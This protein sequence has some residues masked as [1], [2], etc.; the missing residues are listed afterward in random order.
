MDHI[1]DDPENKMNYTFSRKRKPW[2]KYTMGEASPLRTLPLLERCKILMK[3]KSFLHT[4]EGKTQNELRLALLPHLNPL[5]GKLTVVREAAGK[6]RI[7]AIN[8]F[9]TQQVLKPL[10]LWLFEICRYFPQDSTFDQE[11]SLSKFVQRTDMSEYFSYDLSSAT[12]LIPYQIYKAVLSPL[13]GTFLVDNWINILIDKTF[14]LSGIVN[15]KDDPAPKGTS[16]YTRGQPMGALSSW[17]LMNLSHHIINQYAFFVS[18]V[19]DLQIKKHHSAYFKYVEK[20]DIYRIVLTSDDLIPIERLELILPGFIHY[21]VVC[22]FR[23]NLL[24]F[25]RYVV[26][27]DDNV[28]GHRPTAESYF[29]LLTTVYDVPIKLAK[30]YVSSKLINFANQTFF[31]KA[32]ISP[33]PF[34][35]FLSLKGLGSRIEFATRTV[36]RFF[37]KPSIFGLLRYIVNS[38]SWELLKLH[39][40]LGRVYEPVLPLLY[41]VTII[42]L[43]MFIPNW[44][45][46]V[47]K[48]P[49]R[50]FSVVGAVIC[51]TH[52]LYNN[53]VSNQ[54]LEEWYTKV[55]KKENFQS[56]NLRK[57]I[58]YLIK[59]VLNPYLGDPRASTDLDL[60]K[61]RPMD[62][63][64]PSKIA[65]LGLVRQR[66][67]DTIWLDKARRCILR[68]S[69]ILKEVFL[70][71]RRIDSLST[72]EV[73]EILVVLLQEPK[74]LLTI[75]V[76]ERMA[77]ASLTFNYSAYENSDAWYMHVRSIINSDSS[78]DKLT[79]RKD[80]EDEMTT[81]LLKSTFT[82]LDLGGS[83]DM[84][85]PVSVSVDKTT[86]PSQETD[87]VTV[88]QTGGAHCPGDR[89][90]ET[91]GPQA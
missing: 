40:S 3:T 25:D 16:R 74:L 45:D 81:L 71:L 62:R 50:Q 73:V 31:D 88:I 4:V 19:R 30:S 36:R 47:L 28:I 84:N 64:F 27:G 52:S 56:P 44:D 12:D 21:M 91:P 87:G 2:F 13:L 78:D 17:G 33:I 75:R 66:R 22:L 7:I 35:E 85:P 23:D 46:M 63:M 51:L 20:V 79:C 43:P 34:K 9:F 90:S 15:H 14:K 37:A 58:L 76:L 24:P 89:V 1:Y 32:N 83:L 53:V 5:L 49:T 61:V 70:K 54:S 68:K 65:F 82:Y 6:N 10:H 67:Q 72:T 80:H 38:Q 55:G 26:L 18:I 29:E 48:D 86:A 42:K 41:A 39:K 60:T 69:A 11:G 77:K 59:T 57:Y 8:D